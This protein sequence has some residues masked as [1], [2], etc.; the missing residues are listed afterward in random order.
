MRPLAFS[1]YNMG[2]DVPILLWIGVALLVLGLFFA[3]AGRRPA[4]RR[5]ADGT[6][7]AASAPVPK[8]S[9][10]DDA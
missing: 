4:R 1:I 7:P 8:S 6:D 9:F 5:R 2:I 10:T 3:L